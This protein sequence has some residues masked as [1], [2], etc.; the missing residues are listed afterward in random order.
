MLIARSVH[1]LPGDAERRE[2]MLS[3][4][5]GFASRRVLVDVH[6]DRDPLTAARPVER[7]HSKRAGGERATGVQRRKKI[8]ERHKGH[9][10]LFR[11]VSR[12][13]TEV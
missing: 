6:V 7:A 10:L 9:L 8:G 13:N 3:L 1:P 12:I 4:I 2:R 5:D 11:V